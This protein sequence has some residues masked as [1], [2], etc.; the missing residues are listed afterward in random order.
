MAFWLFKQEPEEYSFAD[1]VRDGSTLWDGISNALALKHLRACQKGDRAFFYHTGKEKAIVGIL[2][3]TGPAVP[4]P[5]AD[6]EKLVVV[7]VK[8]IQK[9]KSP[10]TLEAIKADP[11]FADWE[12]VRIGR[13]SVMPCSP[14][15]W[16]QILKMSEQSAEA[17]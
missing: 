6:D 13:L 11:A 2:E 8:P 5:N 4:D 1:F 7:P 16:Q 15:R 3:I 17:I 9:L 10:V 12:L 14:E